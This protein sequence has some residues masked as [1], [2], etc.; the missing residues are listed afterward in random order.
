[1]RPSNFNPQA[2]IFKIRALE[3]WIH[4]PHKGLKIFQALT[5]SLIRKRIKISFPPLWVSISYK[6]IKTFDSFKLN[7]NL[8]SIS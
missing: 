3:L 5:I 4:L 6:F 8:I 2:K 1:M 7:L